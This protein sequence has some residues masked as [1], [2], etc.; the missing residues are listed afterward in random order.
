[1]V[2]VR[3]FEDK[4]AQPL[5]NLMIEM[6]GFYGATIDPDLVIAEDAREQAQRINIVVAYDDTELLGFATFTSL[7][8]VCGLIA[9]T[10]VQQVYVAR[11]ARR[12]G[13]AQVLMGAVARS[14]KA[15]GSTRIEWS[16][17][18]DNTAARALYDGLGAI[19]SAKMYYE[20]DGAALD[21]LAARQQD[22]LISSPPRTEVASA[23]TNDRFRE[24]QVAQ[25]VN[26]LGRYRTDR[27]GWFQDGPLSDE[28]ASERTLSPFFF[29]RP[30]RA[31]RSRTLRRLRRTPYRLAKHR[32][33]QGIGRDRLQ[34]P[35]LERSSQRSPA[36][37]ERPDQE[38]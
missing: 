2:R 10:Y 16:T 36:D 6:A 24:A 7:Y 15:A 23:L 22:T 33:R 19:G 5:A 34:Q 8:P 28:K 12:R 13:V 38:I 18:V 32:Y 1:M 4:D 21:R 31:P 27:L 20:L 9:F 11:A 29:D 30:N 3:S 26:G 37:A 35:C 14:A 17:S 25:P